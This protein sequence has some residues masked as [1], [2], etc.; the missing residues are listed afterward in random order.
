MN[1]KQRKWIN[2]RLKRTLISKNKFSRWAGKKKIAAIYDLRLSATKPLTSIDYYLADPEVALDYIRFHLKN[3]KVI[4]VS[5]FERTYIPI[6]SQA[7]REGYKNIYIY[8]A[9]KDIIDFI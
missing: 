4:L 2:P 7:K 5:E 1:K 9:G 6:V 8:R 3:H